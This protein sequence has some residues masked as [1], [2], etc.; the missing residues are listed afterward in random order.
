MLMQ[1]RKVALLLIKTSSFSPGQPVWRE[2]S[3]LPARF[4]GADVTAA[5][6]EGVD[7][8]GNKRE[9]WDLRNLGL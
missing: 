6:R 1:G 8:Q 3:V 5:V 7:Y 4:P 9:P 2:R